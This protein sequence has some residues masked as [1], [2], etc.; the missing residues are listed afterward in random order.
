MREGAWEQAFA[1]TSDHGQFGACHV[2][3]LGMRKTPSGDVE[4]MR[5]WET[6]ANCLNAMADAS[7]TMH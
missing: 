1:L 3:V 6:L 2:V 7:R 5:G 4:Q